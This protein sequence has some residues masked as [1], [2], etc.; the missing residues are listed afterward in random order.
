MASSQTEGNTPVVSVIVPVYNV[1]KYLT[2]CLDSL[3]SQSA[4]APY[5]I[6]CINDCS[7][8]NCIDILEDYAYRF[9]NLIRVFENEENRGL[10]A[11][12]DRG[13]CEANG[14]YLMFVDSDDYVRSDYVERYL[15][16]MEDNPCDIV[17]GGYID[18][19]GSSETPRFLPHSSWT[20]LC[21]SSACAKLFKKSFVQENCLEFTSIRYAEDTLF[22]LYA[23]AKHPQCAIIDYAGYFYFVNPT[24]ITREKGP[25]KQLERIL[26]SLYRSFVDSFDYASLTQDE[27]WMVEYSYIADMLSTILIFERGCGKETMASKHRFF[28]DD[29]WK[30]FP[31]YKENPFLVSSG[32]HG[33]RGK[34]R[35]GVAI[36]M[37]LDR[38]HF[39]RQLFMFFA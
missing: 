26:S 3:I 10:G 36:F 30:L 24:S 2:R 33:Q 13:I 6:I 9:P 20:T 11:T 34:I 21:F 14:K 7:P 29:L 35:A 19:D 1:E 28:K 27:K 32:P 15:V 22:N 39:D 31:D 37:A 17:I 12:R 25:E 8:D 5:E 4:K 18:T 38:L 16:A 23:F